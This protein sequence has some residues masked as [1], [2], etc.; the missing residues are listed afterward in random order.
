MSDID[1]IALETARAI[2]DIDPDR[3]PGGTV[4]A[5][6]QAQCLIRDAIEQA[7]PPVAVPESSLDWWKEHLSAHIATLFRAN[8]QSMESAEKNASQVIQRAER[9]APQL[10]TPSPEPASSGGV[11]EDSAEQL[12]HER[13]YSQALE[14]RIAELE[15]ATQPTAKGAGVPQGWK[16]TKIKESA[17]GTIRIDTPYGEV[18]P[19]PAPDK[20]SN[21]MEVT[22]YHLAEALLT[23]QPTGG[24]WV[25]CEDRAV[26]VHPKC[27]GEM[28]GRY[29]H[30]QEV[31]CPKCGAIGQAFVDDGGVDFYWFRTPQD[32]E[33]GV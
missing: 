25:R 23:T 24:E 31:T 8:G 29:R 12:Q 5:I 9:I 30:E 22:L 16:F 14:K 19:V 17:R 20:H 6:S 11:L 2:G 26:P 21:Y 15:K 27:G 28:K 3:I 13:R 4:Q 33:G 1:K 32:R 18:S 10:T 7:A